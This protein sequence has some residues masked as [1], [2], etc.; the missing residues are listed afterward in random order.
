MYLGVAAAL[1]TALK[2]SGSIT[3]KRSGNR[4][5]SISY[6]SLILCSSKQRGVSRGGVATSCHRADRRR[7]TV[8]H[9]FTYLVAPLFAALSYE[10]I[11]S[12]VAKTAEEPFLVVNWSFNTGLHLLDQP[13]GLKGSDRPGPV[14]SAAVVKE[15]HELASFSLK[16]IQSQHGQGLRH[17]KD[18]R[19]VASQ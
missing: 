8:E 4:L 12:L 14:G 16:I 3:I 15:L 17:G 18:R 9:S 10:A 2:P 5:K 19:T 13:G 7:G 11:R 1:I 6:G